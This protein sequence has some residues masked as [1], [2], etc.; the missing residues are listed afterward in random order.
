MN[1]KKNQHSL[2]AA[3][4]KSPSRKSLFNDIGNYSIA[5]R[6]VD[7]FSIVIGCYNFTRFVASWTYGF[8][9]DILILCNTTFGQNLV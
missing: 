8:S 6:V 1:L 4:I 5:K 9:Y 2:I 3:L 7:H